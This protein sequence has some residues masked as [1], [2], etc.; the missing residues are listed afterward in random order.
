MK[1]TNV[2]KSLWNFNLCC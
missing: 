2:R 1:T